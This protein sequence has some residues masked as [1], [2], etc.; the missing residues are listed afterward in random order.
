MTPK[1]AE[2]IEET[3]PVMPRPRPLPDQRPKPAVATEREIAIRCAKSLI[4]R[5]T[6]KLAKENDRLRKAEAAADR[7][8]H[9]QGKAADQET[10]VAFT[11][12]SR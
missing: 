12:S 3:T 8:A 10:F 11:I 7:L 5:E 4:V 2:E 9:E 1:A 6:M